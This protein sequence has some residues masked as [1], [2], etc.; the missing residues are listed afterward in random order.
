MSQRNSQGKRS[1]RER[2]REERERQKTAGKRMRVFKVSVVV[3]AVFAVAGMVG[4]LVSQGVKQ[5]SGPAAQPITDGKAQAP[6]TLT[7]YEDFRC[8]GCGHFERNFKETIHELRDT[9]KIKSEYHLVSIID[10]NMGGNGSKHAA[11]AAACA[12]DAGRFTAYHDVLFANQPPESDDTFADKK[13]LIELAGTVGGLD[14]ADFR[15][16]VNEGTHDDWVK[17][18]NDAFTSSEHNATPTVLLNGE[19]IYGDRSDPLT[20]EKLMNLVAEHARNA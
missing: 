2:L 16:C 14:T 7:I 5:G 20:P 9:G 11:N 10:G 17:R 4:V 13:H 1:A 8:P 15:A 18:S 12:R 6:A 3:G 19:D